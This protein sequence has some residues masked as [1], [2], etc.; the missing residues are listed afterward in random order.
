MGQGEEIN[1]ALASVAPMGWISANRPIKAGVFMS[2]V[3]LA[4]FAFYITRTL[5]WS[6]LFL[7][8]PAE[9]GG[10]VAGGLMPIAFSGSSSCN[11]LMAKLGKYKTCKS[12]LHI[13]K[14]EDAD[15]KVLETLIR[16]S[17]AYMKKKYNA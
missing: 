13:N 9:F 4:V 11:D 10:L 6:E 1:P 8:L 5:G 16:K 2:F 12:C 3:R 7:L 14:L 15:T 17:V